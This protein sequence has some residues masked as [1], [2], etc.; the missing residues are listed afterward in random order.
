MGSIAGY[1]WGEW[2]YQETPIH[3]RIGDQPEAQMWINHP[4]ETLHGGFGRPS[5]WGGCGTLPRVQ[6]YRGLAVVLF[7]THDGQPDFTHAWLPQS[8]FDEKQ[9]DAARILLRGGE[10]M[11][12]LTGNRPFE[13][14]DGGPTRECEVRLAGRETCWLIRLNDDP[15]LTTL[16]QFASHFAGLQV[17]TWGDGTLQVC[18]ANYG[19]VLFYADGRVQ[20]QGRTLDPATWT[21]DG[22]SRELTL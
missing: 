20:A 3:L 2:G 5:Y 22:E 1:R 13:V 4:G 7:N 21:V 6:Q 8:A 15:A 10:G 9:I 16:A 19:E 17:E 18:D 11:V 12:Q 14:V